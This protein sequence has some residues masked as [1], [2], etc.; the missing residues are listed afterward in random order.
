MGQQRVAIAAGTLIERT[1]A[2]TISTSHRRQRSRVSLRINGGEG[3]PLSRLIKGL[4]RKVS[5]LAPRYLYHIGKTELTIQN[6]RS[7]YYMVG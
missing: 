1:S 5:G 2:I 7:G 4:R 3:Q 6:P